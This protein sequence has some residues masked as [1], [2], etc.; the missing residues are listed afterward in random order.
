[1]ERFAGRRVLVTGAGSGMG[2]AVAIR[3]LREGGEVAA[4]DISG[5]GLADTKQR[6]GDEGVAERLAVVR[7]D[8]TDELAVGEAVGE[9]TSRLGG[10]DVLVNAA[11]ILRAARTEECGLD[12]WNQ[13]LLTNLTGTF[14]VTRAALPALLDGGGVIVNFS[15]TAASHGHPYM[16]AYAASKGGIA[17][18]TQTLAIEY[19]KRGVRAVAIAPGGVATPLMEEVQLPDDADFKLLTRL[20]PIGRGFAEPDEV[21]AVVATIASDEGAYLNGTVVRI[22]GGTH[23]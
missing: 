22:D 13:V 19:A 8:V 15:S 11:G 5:D 2:R 23:A 3:I 7:L 14:L 4:C 9:V 18:F 10:L 21:A 20:M 6:A 1:M 17:A 12:L 16:A